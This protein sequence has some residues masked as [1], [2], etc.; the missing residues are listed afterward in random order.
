MPADLIQRLPTVSRRFISICGSEALWQALYTRDF[1]VGRRAEGEGGSEGG[2]GAGGEGVTALYKDAYLSERERRGSGGG[3]VVSADVGGGSEGGG[4]RGV[5]VARGL[6]ANGE[7]EAILSGSGAHC[8]PPAAST[9]APPSVGGGG[10]RLDNPRH[11]VPP[12]LGERRGLGVDGDPGGEAAWQGG[13]GMGGMG[14][15]GGRGGEFGGGLPGMG[16]GNRGGR[17]WDGGGRRPGVGYGGEFEGFS[18]SP[19]AP[20][21]TGGDR[22]PGRAGVGY[23]GE[24]EGFSLS[25]Q[26]PRHF[27]ENVPIGWGGDYDRSPLTGLQPGAP[28]LMPPPFRPR[29]ADQLYAP[30]VRPFEEYPARPPE[31]RAGMPGGVGGLGQQYGAITIPVPSPYTPA[32]GVPE[33]WQRVGESGG[34]QPEGGRMGGREGWSEVGEW[35]VFRAQVMDEGVLEGVGGNP[36]PDA[37]PPHFI[38]DGSQTHRHGHLGTG[39]DID[40]NLNYGESSTSVSDTFY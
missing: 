39:T 26:V 17:P 32:H 22:G 1:S 25:P 21:Q 7:F 15:R 13:G 2:R 19:Q 23:G 29:G 27:I 8:A 28:P 9:P 33:S 5:A 31:G 40:Y 20:R 16:G 24:F 35:N 6:G 14:G 12:N 30:P 11:R 36:Q 38:P 34:A 18:L 37:P 10:S 3:I 4:A